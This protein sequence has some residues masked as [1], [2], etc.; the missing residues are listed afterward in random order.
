[1]KTNFKEIIV[2]C[3]T[4]GLFCMSA[5][6]VATE[7]S[8]EPQEISMN[9]CKEPKEDSYTKNKACK[10]GKEDTSRKSAARKVIEGS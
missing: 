8:Q 9:S 4:A 1:M 2:V 10:T 6:T 3:L 7:E 5:E